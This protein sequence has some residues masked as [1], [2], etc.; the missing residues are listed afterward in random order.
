MVEVRIAQDNTS[1]QSMCILP[2]GPEWV[3][4]HLLLDGNIFR[5]LAA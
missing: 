3:Y 2:T 5:G 1:T 4:P